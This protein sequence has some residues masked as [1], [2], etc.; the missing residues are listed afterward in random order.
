MGARYIYIYCVFP[1]IISKSGRVVSMSDVVH[2]MMG[3][4][5]SNL[6]GG[7]SF[8][9]HFARIFGIFQSSKKHASEFIGSFMTAGKETSL[10]FNTYI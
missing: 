9:I 8:F 2:Q 1:F 4:E 6:S 5:S 7:S 3:V 10:I